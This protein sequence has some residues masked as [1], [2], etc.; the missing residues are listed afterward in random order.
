MSRISARKLRSLKKDALQDYQERRVLAVRIRKKI[1][2]ELASETL[3]VGA[4]KTLASLLR[5]ANGGIA[6]VKSILEAEYSEA[7]DNGY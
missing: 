7:L 5:A 4:L 1:M 3:N 6:E 2:E